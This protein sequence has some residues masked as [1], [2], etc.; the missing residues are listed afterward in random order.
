MIKKILNKLPIIALIFSLVLCFVSCKENDP[1]VED[2]GDKD[3]VSELK[4]DMESET[5]KERVTVK[6]Y[7]DGDTTHFFVTTS[8]IPGGVLQARYLAINTPES[9]GKIE[10]WGKKASKFTQETLSKATSIIIESDDSNWN[11]DST[12]GRY[13]V[14]VWYRTSEDSDYRNLNVEILQN[15][16]ALAS[17]SG[18]NRYGEICLAAL[19][20]ARRNKLYLYSGEKD[21]DFYYGDAAEI[22]LKELRFNISEYEGKKVAFEGNIIANY[23]NSIYL[24][25]Y[26]EETGICYGIT[27][28][29][30]YS[31]NG[32]GLRIVS[33]GNRSR[34]VG[35]V[36]Y[37]AAGDIYQVSGIEYRPFKPAD[38]VS[39]V[40][41]GVTPLYVETSINELFNEKVKVIDEENGTSKELRKYDAMLYTSVSLYDLTVNTVRISDSS[42]GTTLVLGCTDG[43]GKVISVKVP[44]VTDGSGNIDKSF[45]QGQTIDVK[46]LITI[47]YGDQLIRVFDDENIRIK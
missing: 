34:I 20:Q 46:G 32:D 15:G 19:A 3:F 35:T 42:S 28:Y 6:Q 9:T 37:Y 29:L 8:A 38:S 2:D 5:L 43:S 10:E 45:Y 12:G 18:Q 41:E 1:P 44:A 16:L 13:L 39:L 4:L 36:Q 11:L 47:D 31:L 22:T 23:N 27:V 21:P 7:V 25:D 30:G 33:M 26:D 17:N 14:W 40:E 24:E